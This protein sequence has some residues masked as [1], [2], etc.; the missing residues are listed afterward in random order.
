MIGVV[1]D[2]NVV[3]SAALSESGFPASILDLVANGRITMFVSAE[4]LEEYD[5]VLRRPRLKLSAARIEKAVELIR[6][7]SRIVWPKRKL[8]LALDPDDNLFYECAYAAKADFLIT[9]NT[10]HFSLG[11]ECTEIVTPRQNNERL[12]PILFKANR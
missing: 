6:S 9:G 4:V 2:T 8:E 1:V 3:V 5:E 11:H 7:T 10:K 12:G